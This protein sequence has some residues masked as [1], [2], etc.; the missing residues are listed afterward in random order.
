MLD[1]SSYLDKPCY[2]EYSSCA[3]CGEQFVRSDETVFKWSPAVNHL[4]EMH[5]VCADLIRQAC[6]AEE[7]GIEVGCG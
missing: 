7:S 5:V 3:E 6:A 2:G 4:A 1:Y